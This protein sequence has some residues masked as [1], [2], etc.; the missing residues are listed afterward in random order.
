M[1]TTENVL[2]VGKCIKMMQRIFKDTLP[3]KTRLEK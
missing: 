1:S 2:A 3:G